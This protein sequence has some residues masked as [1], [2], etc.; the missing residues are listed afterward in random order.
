MTSK[1]SV[2]AATSL[3]NSSEDG[4]LDLKAQSVWDI[5]NTAVERVCFSSALQQVVDEPPSL[6]AAVT[7]VHFYITQLVSLSGEEVDD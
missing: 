4:R 3:E 6:H 5:F 2:G 1:C 7:L